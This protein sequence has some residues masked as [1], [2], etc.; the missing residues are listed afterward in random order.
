MTQQLLTPK[1]TEQFTFCMRSPYGQ[2]IW[3]NERASLVPRK[4]RL[5]VRP[6]SSLRTSGSRPEAMPDIAHRA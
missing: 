5:I 2:D 6:L 3:C 1:V 4:V